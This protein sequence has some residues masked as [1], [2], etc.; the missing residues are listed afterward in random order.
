[1]NSTKSLSRSEVMLHIGKDVEHY[2]AEFLKPIETNWQ[3]SELL[4]LTS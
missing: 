4:P 2:T 3:A 1:M